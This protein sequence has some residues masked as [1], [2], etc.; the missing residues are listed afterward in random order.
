MD[1]PETEKGSKSTG[2]EQS[3]GL[4]QK[5]KTKGEVEVVIK[6]PCLLHSGVLS[7]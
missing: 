4:K 7:D 3:G 2:H 6:D 1:N 5:R